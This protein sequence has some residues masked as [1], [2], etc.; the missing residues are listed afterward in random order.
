VSEV[1]DWLRVVAAARAAGAGTWT[2]GGVMVCR[3]DGGFNNALYRVETGGSC[4]ACKLC[5]ADERRRAAREYG[6]LRLLRAAGLV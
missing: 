4:Y 5:V 3:V 2:E 6:A 1:R